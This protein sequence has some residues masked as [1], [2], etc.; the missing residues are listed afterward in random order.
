MMV[1]RISCKVRLSGWVSIGVCRS[2]LSAAAAGA[3]R[4]QR[5]QRV[6][7]MWV[8]FILCKVQS[9]IRDLYQIVKALKGIFL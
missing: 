9:P 8:G 6:V 4:R 2:M 5:R 7:M 1:S 3:M